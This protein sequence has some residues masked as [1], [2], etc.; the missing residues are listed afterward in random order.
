VVA[1]LGGFS[2]SRVDVPGAA[3]SRI[4]PSRS[5]ILTRCR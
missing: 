4:F 3:L 2:H 5:G 1:G